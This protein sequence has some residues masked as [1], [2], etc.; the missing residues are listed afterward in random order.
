LAPCGRAE[1]GRRPLHP[2]FVSSAWALGATESL[3]KQ[4]RQPAWLLQTKLSQKRRA[5]PVAQSAVA[6]RRDGAG[7]ASYP[8][9][10]KSSLA[11]GAAGSL[12]SYPP[13]SRRSTWASLG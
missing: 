10:G 7:M 8:A 1:G 2:I 3:Q 4:H 12:S 6:A 11:M 13:L 5:A 9:D